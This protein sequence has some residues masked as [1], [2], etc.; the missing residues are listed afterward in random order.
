MGVKIPPLV[1]TRR[2]LEVNEY[3]PG[4]RENFK[5]WKA[6][7]TAIPPPKESL[8][9][10]YIRRQ[11]T[12]KSL[13][14]P[15]LG[16]D[17][18]WEEVDMTWSSEEE[19]NVDRD[20][21]TRNVESDDDD[22][23]QDD[24]QICSGSRGAAQAR[25]Q[26]QFMP[27]EFGLKFLVER[28]QNGDQYTKMEAAGMIE[29]QTVKGTRMRAAMINFMAKNN[30]VSSA[31]R[32]REQVKLYEE[33][34]RLVDGGWGIRGRPKKVHPN[35][36]KAF[37]L[38]RTVLPLPNEPL[39]ID[40]LRWDDG[41]RAKEKLWDEVGWKGKV[42]LGVIPV[43]FCDNLSDRSELLKKQLLN[44]HPP[45]VNI[46]DYLGQMGDPVVKNYDPYTNE[47]KSVTWK[48]PS[49]RN[50]RIF[51]LYCPRSV[52]HPPAKMEDGGSNETFSSLKD[53]IQLAAGSRQDNDS[54]VVC[55]GGRSCSK[56]F[57]CQRSR[58]CP[59]RFTVCWDEVG[60]YIHLL[61]S[62]NKWKTVGCPW[63]TCCQKSILKRRA[64]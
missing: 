16:D 59:F 14:D 26:H 32:L 61:S 29:R 37:K 9:D 25:Y 22:G 7:K 63:H 23:I 11:R 13:F 46:C 41:E 28:P 38:E 58:K 52:W 64:A 50:E 31:K 62:P 21:D 53:E 60:Y 55:I 34:N 1:E 20:L 2:K 6:A 30:Y 18:I 4:V 15:Q 56:V 24:D 3:N 10:E 36:Q 40:Q 45:E 17:W 48:R 44:K 33:G 19:V 39:I 57:I 12:Q 35:H 54:P 47:K 51:R 49:N 42:Y 5:K 27:S 8:A 43:R